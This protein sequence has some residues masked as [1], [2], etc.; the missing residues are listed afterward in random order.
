MKKLFVFILITLFNTILYSQV[1]E[2]FKYQA[3][4]RNSSGEI[5]NDKTISLKIS[6]VKGDEIR[7]IVY[8]E[9]HSVTTN[10]YGLISLNI[11]QGNSANDFSIIQWGND[12]YFTQIEM[13]LDGGGDFTMLGVSQLLSVPYALYA[14]NVMN[15][16][17]LDSDTTNEIQIL[18]ISNDT[19]FL[20]NGGFVKLPEDKVNDPDADSTN[21]IQYFSVSNI[22]D[23]LFLS[24][25][26]YIIMPGVSKANQKSGT[27]IDARD[28]QEYKWVE[29]GN[30][31]WMA[32]NLN[33]ETVSGSWAYDNDI[34]FAN[35]YGRLYNYDTAQ[36]VC[37]SGWHLSSDSEWTELKTYLI[38]NGYN[39]DNS[40]EENKIGKSLAET[41]GWAG[42]VEIG[43]VGNDQESNNATGFSALPGGYRNESGSFGF[44]GNWACFWSS[45]ESDIP[46]W[47][48][49]CNEVGLYRYPYH[50]TF[51]FSVRCVKD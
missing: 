15:N 36:N 1:P 37:P 51:G 17:D 45:S 43:D 26:N 16:S 6:I 21:E 9:T 44:R 8:E 46:Y 5:V 27:F 48:L 14:K 25:S 29:I 19:I 49:D 10:Q 39:Y 23:T 47:L 3:V 50:K 12:S 28:S 11:G 42:S 32:E 35:T 30:Q 38:V 20:E 2:S 34:S 22:G 7:D 41:N 18:S 24:E 13:D 33:Y 4:I 40:T 31:I